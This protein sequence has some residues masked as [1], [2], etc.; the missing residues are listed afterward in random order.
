MARRREGEISLSAEDSEVMAAARA[1][2]VLEGLAAGLPS[3]NAL[4]QMLVSI[5]ATLAETYGIPEPVARKRIAVLDAAHTEL[6]DRLAQAGRHPFD[7]LTEREG[8]ILTRGLPFTI[9]EAAE[10]ARLSV[11]DYM[12]R[13]NGRPKAFLA[14]AFM[15]CGITE[16]AIAA[17]L[18]H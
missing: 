14:V 4:G 3:D 16:G 9:E 13:A 11:A 17:T 7:D 1:V 8:A 10:R 6:L 12:P 2:P 5:A 18:D 15:S